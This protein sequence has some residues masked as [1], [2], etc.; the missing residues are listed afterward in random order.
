MNKP[1]HWSGWP[2][3][4]CLD[5]GC[6]DPIEVALAD[7]AIPDDIE[8]THEPCLGGWHPDTCGQCRANMPESKEE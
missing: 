6:E 7:G 3:A 1:H 5:C 4:H 2:G 8:V